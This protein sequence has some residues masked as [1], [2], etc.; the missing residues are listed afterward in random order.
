MM[1]ARAG[2]YLE[3]GTEKYLLQDAMKLGARVLSSGLVG[4]AV[5]GRASNGGVSRSYQEKVRY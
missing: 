4:F 3:R 1:L 2:Y 5:N